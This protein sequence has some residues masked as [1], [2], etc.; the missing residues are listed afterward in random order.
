MKLSQVAAQLWTVRDHCQ[1]VADFATSMKKIKAIGYGAVQLSGHGPIA[2]ADIVRICTGEGLTICA[3]HERGKVICESPEM[4]VD[5]LNELGCTYTAYPWPHLGFATEADA[6]SLATSL[7][8]S[9]AILAKAGKVLGYHNHA[10]EFKRFSGK[11]VL[12]ILYERTDPKN[13]QGEIDT[14]W[15]QAGGGD[16]V[17]WC[18]KLK[19]RLPLL[20]IKD[21]GVTA[22]GNGG[23][24]MEIG[25]GNLD[26]KRI[27]AAAEASGCKWF[28]VE[29]DTCP[30]DPFD[31]LGISYRYIAA[32]LVERAA[33]GA[34]G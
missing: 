31:S 2:N 10:L 22:D 20:H 3:T 14:Y 17:A 28:I 30:G 11:P 5:T 12:E 15:V 16:P 27:I 4:V 33:P 13:L 6:V 9:G 32:N 26:W 7:D 8:R 21:Y 23:E 24:I 19:N 1:T 18:A 25:N 34:K 29:Q